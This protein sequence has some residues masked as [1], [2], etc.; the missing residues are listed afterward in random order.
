MRWVVIS[1]LLMNALYFGWRWWQADTP[2]PATSSDREI[3]L[4]PQ[5]VQINAERRLPIVEEDVTTQVEPM[6]DWRADESTATSDAITVSNSQPT[7]SSDSQA[8]DTQTHSATV[9]EP[10]VSLPETFCYWTDWQENALEVNAADVLERQQQEQESGRS[11]LVWI[12]PKATREETLERL[13]ELKTMD[14][15]SAYINRGEQKGGISLGLF[16]SEESVQIRL[17]D[18]KRLGIDDARTLTRVRTQ[19]MHRA[20][21]RQTA[22]NNENIPENW[23]KTDCPPIAPSTDAQ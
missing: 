22:S 9:Q 2:T 18:A 13:R 19:T 4:S 11:Y 15:E 7:A 3:E 1:L 23:Q 6:P 17:N 21:I 20:L 12:E 14:I 8:V 5:S 16:S 10:L